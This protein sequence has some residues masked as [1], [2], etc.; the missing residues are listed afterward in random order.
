MNHSYRTR[1]CELTKAWGAAEEL[2]EIN[3][4][5]KIEMEKERSYKY[6]CLKKEMAQLKVTEVSL[7]GQEL[8]GEM[9]LVMSTF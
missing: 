2:V 4:A 6:T 5:G 7:E 9:T 8:K 1:R 3:Q